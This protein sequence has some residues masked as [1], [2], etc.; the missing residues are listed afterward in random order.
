MEEA[1]KEKYE[2]HRP[3][4]TKRSDSTDKE[5]DRSK[6]KAEIEKQLSDTDDNDEPTEL[7][8]TSTSS[9][10]PGQST[11]YAF[12]GGLPGNEK[13]RKKSATAGTGYKIVGGE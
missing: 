4:F 6:N 11:A 7:K 8:E 5:Y 2:P 12:S 1:K 10:T 13:H 9:A 3:L